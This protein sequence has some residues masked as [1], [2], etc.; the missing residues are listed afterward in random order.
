MDY[1]DISIELSALSEELR[2]AVFVIHAA[3]EQFSPSLDHLD[4]AGRLEMLSLHGWLESFICSGLMRIRDELESI[5]DA[6]AES[7]LEN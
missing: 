2:G 4:S 1:T 5:A 3:F 7:A 6:A